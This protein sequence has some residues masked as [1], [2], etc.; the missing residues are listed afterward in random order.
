MANIPGV[1]IEIGGKKRPTHFGM[2]AFKKAESEAGRSFMGFN[3]EEMFVGDIVELIHAALWSGA[4]KRG[5]PFEHEVWDVADWMDDL[6]ESE[7]DRIMRV[8][9]DAQGDGE[10]KQAG[11]PQGP[12]ANGQLAALQT[13]MNS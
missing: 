7:L 1:D 4:R 13:G 11:N 10:D 6:D 12:G 8:A 2:A 9:R 5:V 3:V